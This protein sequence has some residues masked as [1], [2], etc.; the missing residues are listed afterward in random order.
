MDLNPHHWVSE[1]GDYLF[2]IAFL[3]I[4]H[5][6]T[7]EDLVQD[8]FLSAIR[9]LDT[10]RK[11][12]SV[13]TW[14]VS[15]LNNKIIDHYRKR[16]TLQGPDEYLS[17]TDDPFY[18]AFFQADRYSDAHW[19]RD[20]RPQ[21]WDNDTESELLRDEFFRVLE[22]CIHRMPSRLIPVFTAKFI[23]EKNSEDICKDLA[24]SPS[25]YWVMIHRSKLLMR[26]C[27]EKSWIKR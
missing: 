26:S 24:I 13:K 7:A 4:N 15:I 1:Y 11:E 17:K 18:S 8:T 9:S 5:R 3:K 16:D 2:S 12:S 20:S 6:E 19:K 21:D 25:N 27:L 23:D 14:L 10:F 22:Y